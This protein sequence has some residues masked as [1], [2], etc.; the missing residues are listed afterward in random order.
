MNRL[1][2]LILPLGF[3]STPAGVLGGQS[4]CP[5]E[6][7]GLRD[8]VVAYAGGDVAARPASVPMRDPSHVRLL[9]DGNPLDRYACERLNQLVAS[10]RKDRPGTLDGLSVTYYD[11]DGNYYAVAAPA[12]PPLQ[13]TAPVG[14]D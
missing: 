2:L 4:T 1:L 3:A 13:E 14:S 6:T 5:G 12:T 10:Q 8:L 9:L 11:V 7:P